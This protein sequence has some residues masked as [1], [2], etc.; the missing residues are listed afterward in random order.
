MAQGSTLYR[1]KIALSDTDR[2][3]YEALDFRAA[4]HPSESVDF[5]LTRV[6]AY[7]LNY[8]PGLEFSAGLSTTDEPAIRLPDAQG[9]I[10]KWIDIGN[11][12]ARRMHKAAK[13][14]RTVRVY[15]YKDPENL[16]REAAGEAIHRAEEIEIFSL[17]PS[18]LR[19]LAQA[20]A[21][22]NTWGLIHTE[23]ELILTS[24]EET[25]MGQV[26]RHRLEP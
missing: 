23:G 2:A 15:T 20:L 25:W 16:K 4:M 21:K 10:A 3:V 1:F 24:G 14:A 26:T 8:E 11:P 9:G 18:F 13:A 22:E 12:T 17:D 5:L 19:P 6:L 7:A